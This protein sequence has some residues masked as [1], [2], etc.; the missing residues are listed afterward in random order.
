MRQ[1]SDPSGAPSSTA[2]AAPRQVREGE[3][4]LTDQQVERRERNREHAKRS[5]I[6]KKFLLE[7]LQDQMASL[8]TE[9]T[10]LRRVVKEKVSV[11]SV[12]CARDPSCGGVDGQPALHVVHLFLRAQLPEKASDILGECTTEFS[13]VLAPDA[14]LAQDKRDLVEQDFKLIEVTTSLPQLQPPRAMVV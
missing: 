9:N 2:T 5:R 13:T 8:R 11:L 14:A 7:S 10:Y 3:K 4:G 1:K 12:T 6:R